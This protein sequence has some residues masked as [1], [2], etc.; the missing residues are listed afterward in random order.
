VVDGYGYIADP[1][2]PTVTM[3]LDK[4]VTGQPAAASLMAGDGR[5]D[6]ERQERATAQRPSGAQQLQSPA[7]GDAATLRARAESEARP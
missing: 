1:I 5:W 2:L 3:R 7:P 4:P 6:G